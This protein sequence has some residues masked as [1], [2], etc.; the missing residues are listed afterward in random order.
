[1]RRRLTTYTRDGRADEDYYYS[2]FNPASVVGRFV[3]AAASGG[4][5]TR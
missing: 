4:T 2:G 1:M 3:Y 5:T